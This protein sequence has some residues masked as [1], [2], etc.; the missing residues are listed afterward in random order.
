MNFIISFLFGFLISSTIIADLHEFHLSKSMMKYNQEEKAIQISL[1]LFIDDF[2]EALASKGADS[3]NLFKKIEHPRADEYI[4]LY[5]KDRL[6]IIVDDQELEFEYIGK[7][8]SEDLAGIWMYLEILN[9]EVP[10]S[11]EVENRLLIEMF[12]DQRNIMNV[13]A[14]GKSDYLMFTSEDIKQKLTWE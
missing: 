2:E 8:M 11:I 13:S 5:L 6:H 4:Q 10:E 7:E 14:N 9:V 12:E 3:M 1:H